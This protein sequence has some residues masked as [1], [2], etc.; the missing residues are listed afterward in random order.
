MNY[1]HAYH[2]GNFADVVKHAILARV[3]T[4]LKLKP[5][6]FRVIDTHAG[7]GRYD[8]SGVE[9]A[10]TG[11][12]R[13]G[14]GRLINCDI[15][16]DAAALLAPYLDAVRA[17]N[18]EGALTFYPG[19]PVIARHLMRPGDQLVANELHSEDLAALKTEMRRTPDTKVLG[20][21]AW[22]AVKS[23]LPPPERRG[24]I[25]IDPPFEKA[26]EFERLTEAL[27]NGLERFATGV[28]IVWYPVKN[29]ASADRFVR[30]ACRLGG[31]DILDV[32]LTICEPFAGLGLTETGLLIVNP[33]FSLNG[34]LERIL[35]FLVERLG[36]GRGAG[37]HLNPIGTKV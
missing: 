5:Q 32:R 11:E 19:S 2:A 10:K 29:A 34:E 18:F 33:P 24:L 30:D 35:P 26:D 25:L 14:I 12:W 23:L 28:Y 20:L 21:D 3:L 7:A 9:A 15:P 8:L 17:V 37:F 27:A 6:P 36:E 4:Y 16:D 22:L 31:R 1:R 13:D